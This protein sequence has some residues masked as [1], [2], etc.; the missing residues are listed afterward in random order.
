MKKKEDEKD[1]SLYININVIITVILLI[2]FIYLFFDYCSFNFGIE[3]EGPNICQYVVLNKTFGSIYD[4]IYYLLT[5][6]NMALSIIFYTLLLAALLYYLYTINM[7]ETFKEFILNEL[8]NYSTDK[9]TYLNKFTTFDLS[10]FT[11]KFYNC[12][13]K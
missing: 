4:F 10:F 7:L 6:R 13:T 1:S 11:T 3:S 2:S 9:N 5:F 12:A 8:Y